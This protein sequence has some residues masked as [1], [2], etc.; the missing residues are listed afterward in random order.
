MPMSE[1]LG[2]G[3]ENREGMFE[4]AIPHRI[5]PHHCLPED[6][7]EQIIKVTYEI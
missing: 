4:L 1:R 2:G 3:A 7:T 6:F 5:A